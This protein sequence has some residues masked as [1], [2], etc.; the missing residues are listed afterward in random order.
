MLYDKDIREDLYDFLDYTFGKNRTFDEKEMGKSRADIIDVTETC[1]IG[2]EI[3]S[4][5][6]TYARLKRQMRDYNKYCDLCYVVIGK[7]HEKHVSEHVQKHWGII[8]AYKEDEQIKF[9]I[10]R[11][12]IPNPKIKYELQMTF[13]WRPELN[14]L[15]EINRLP[16]YKN[17]SKKFVIDKLL[18]KV[19][20]GKLKPQICNELLERDYDMIDEYFGKTSIISGS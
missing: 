6:D 1:I 19:E 7:R 9:K 18:E 2:L 10:E 15:L 5:M 4:D 12:A 11:E 3:K 14:R 20:L 8:V 16:K 13:L 17:K